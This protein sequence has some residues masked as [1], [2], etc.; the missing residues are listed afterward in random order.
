MRS[1]R[2]TWLGAGLLSYRVREA[3]SESL[4][5]IPRTC[6]YRPIPKGPFE[7]TP[8]RAVGICL[9]PGRRDTPSPDIR[10]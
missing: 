1:P 6:H 5:E 7:N 8:S 4:G 9:A 2:L 10:E 3:K